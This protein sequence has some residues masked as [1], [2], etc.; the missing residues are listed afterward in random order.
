MAFSNTYVFGFAATICVV[1][2]L[3]IAG[4]SMSL[5]ERQ[6]LNKE[7]DVHKNIL[8]ALG[9]PEDGSV[10]DGPTIDKLWA[11]RIEQRFV[12]PTGQQAGKELDQDGDGDLDQKDLDLALD[13]AGLDG[14]PAVLGVYV[15]KDGP[16]DAAL[17][18]PMSGKGLWG[19]VSGYLAIDPKA[20]TVTG[21]TFFAPAETP[22]LGAEIMEPPFK[23]QWI[24]KKIVDGTNKTKPVRV[25]K[26]KAADLCPGDLDHCV[27]GVSGATLTIRG[28]D[29]MVVSA[30]GWYDPFLSNLRGG[31]R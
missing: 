17:A 30:L 18:L 8:A 2:S 28:V 22:G 29:K 10:P 27:D 15:R 6:Q 19:P 26:G 12:T 5:R 21:V 11:E 4:V 24:G 1:C 3:S 20:T 25:V 16:S 7:R 13:V 23:N 9:L 31:S 14:T